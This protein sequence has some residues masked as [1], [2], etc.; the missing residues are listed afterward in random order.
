VNVRKLS[1]TEKMN[2]ALL[3]MLD[4]DKGFSAKKTDNFLKI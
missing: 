3:L 4:A 2:R 1:R